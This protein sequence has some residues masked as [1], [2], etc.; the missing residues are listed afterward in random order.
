M[1][2]RARR[3]GRDVALYWKKFEKVE[4]GARRKAEKE[5]LEQR[6]MDL[7]LQEASCVQFCY[8]AL[9]SCLHIFPCVPNQL[10]KKVSECI[11]EHLF[12]VL[13]M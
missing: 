11:Y 2:N 10:A 1:P 13:R 9:G 12:L 7:E 3:L 4:K 6:K 8:A 5:A